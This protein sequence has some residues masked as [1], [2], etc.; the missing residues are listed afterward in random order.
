MAMNYYGMNC[1]HYAIELESL[2][3]LALLLEGSWTP[4]KTEIDDFPEAPWLRSAWK[5]LDMG[6]KEDGLLPIHVAA[7][8]GNKKIIKYIIRIVNSRKGTEDEYMNESEMLEYRAKYSMTPLLIAVQYN[9]TKCFEYLNGIG[10][11]IYAKNTRMQNSLHLAAIN[12][13]KEIVEQIMAIDMEEGK[14]RRA[15]DYRGKI[16]MQY[17]G[18]IDI[19]NALLSIWEAIETGSL[20]DIQTIMELTD[21]NVL[22]CKHSKFGDTPLHYAVKMKKIGVVQ[23]LMEYKASKDIANIQMKTPMDLAEE[24]ENNETRKA[25]INALNSEGKEP[26][27]LKKL[28]ELKSRRPCPGQGLGTPDLCCVRPV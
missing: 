1:I 6:T 2:P 4:S 5:A 26:V 27:I 17:T 9:I 7:M 11:D 20:T 23:I 3:I 25:I 15:K 14:L 16:P 24:I 10:S 21:G 12:N 18:K 19:K 28:I 22:K 8:K 13:N